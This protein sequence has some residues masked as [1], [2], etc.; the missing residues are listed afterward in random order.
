MKFLQLSLENFRGIKQMDIDFQGADCCIYGSNA[1]GKTTVANAICWLLTGSAITGE[2]DFSPKTTGTHN[3]HHKA[4]LYIEKDGGGI[5]RLSK[6]FYEKWTKKKGAA[7]AELTGHTTDFAVDGV[8][9]KEKDY[10]KA[11]EALC[12]GSMDMIKIMSVLG[13]FSETLKAD[14]RRRIL[15]EVCGD[16]PDEEI[17]QDERLNAL[18]K[19][20]LMPG[21]TDQHYGIDDYRAIAVKQR[22]KLKKELDTLPERIDEQNSSL[23]APVD[24]QALRKE[25][26][27]LQ[28]LRDELIDSDRSAAKKAAIKGL[29]ADM[30]ARKLKHIQEQGKL[31]EAVNGEISRLMAERAAKEFD[32]SGIENNIR[33]GRQKAEEMTRRRQELLKDWQEIVSKKWDANLAICPCCGQALPAEQVEEKRANF[34]ANIDECK[35]RI[36]EDGKKCSDALIQ[37]LKAELE[38]KQG[39]ADNLSKKIDALQDEINKAR[40]RLQVVVPFEETDSCKEIAARIEQL[41]A[42]AEDAGIVR[43]QVADTDRR[44]D[45]INSQLASIRMAEKIKERIAELETL[46]QEKAAQLENVEHGLFLCDE[47]IRI[48]VAMVTDRINSRFKSISFQLF[49]EQ[50]NGGIKECCDALIPSPDGTMVEYKAAN[51]AAK[52][53]A[54]LEIISVLGEHYGMNLPVLV[55]QAE[56]VVS[57]AGISQQVISLI[58]SAEYK[59]LY[60]KLADKMKRS[61]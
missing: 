24:E 19:F 47:F 20:L 60:V 33:H 32:L 35:A 41:T 55:D 36:R 38:L 40:G 37:Q 2:K 16:M 6:D 44:M 18:P 58:V 8:P 10:I 34:L 27:E 9:Q 23:P 22:A 42:E 28:G 11:V 46:Q 51:T 39:E 4:E 52:I 7:T 1:T 61:A 15:L 29:R 14:D 21:T 12:G 57:L 49:K 26:A 17:M 30:E 48:K 25:L 54:G 45:E 13:Y 56:S 5:V 3:L 50:V 31:N 53:N 59:R 43:Q